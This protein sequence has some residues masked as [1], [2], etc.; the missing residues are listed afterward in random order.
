MIGDII[1]REIVSVGL[2]FTEVLN[3]VLEGAEFDCFEL[4]D[5]E[6]ALEICRI[7]AEVFI[8]PENTSILMGGNSYPIH[9][10]QDVYEQLTYEHIA[11]VIDNFKEINYP[12]KKKKAYIRTALYNSVFEYE[13][14]IEN[15]YRTYR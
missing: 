1:N 12:I 7:I 6:F 8:L 11:R 10:V 9:T 5:R 13:T 3:S 14:G 15:E 4:K 2:S